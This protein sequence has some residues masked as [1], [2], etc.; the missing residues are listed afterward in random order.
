M[1]ISC[2]IVDDE[3][4]CIKTIKD[5]VERTPGLELIGTES[6]PLEA[7]R[8]ILTQEIKP[9]VV[10]LDIK[11]PQ[12]SGIELARLIKDKTK[13]IFATSHNNH[14]YQSYDLGALDFL[15][16]PVSY[17]RFLQAIKKGY[18]QQAQPLRD[19]HPFIFV[20]TENKKKLIKVDTEEITTIEGLSNYVKINTS[21]AK[22]YTVYT[23]MKSLLNKLPSAH[24]IRS[25]KS[26]IVNLKFVEMITG[27]EILMKGNEVIPIGD[28][29][30][31]QLYGCL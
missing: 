23:S 4:H 10:F 26:Y 2:Y 7:L 29:F 20:Q 13:V 28:F 31:K 9:D 14:A 21:S 27:N 16:K 3:S 18:S 15:I 8:K 12:L 19:V 17:E 25:H 6:N 1:K 30:K 24:F 22:T 11:M 5:H